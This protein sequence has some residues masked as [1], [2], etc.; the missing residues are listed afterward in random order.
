MEESKKPIHTLILDSGPILKNDPGVSSLLGQAEVLM[1]VP[2]VITEIRDIQARSRLE[3]TLLPFLTQRE[4]RPESLQVIA[5]FARKTGDYEVLSRTD[6]QVLALA[7]DVECERNEGDWR[8]RKVPGQKRVNGA[9]PMNN[10]GLSQEGEE[11]L[12]VMNEEVL[13]GQREQSLDGAENAQ[14]VSTAAGEVVD[15][16]STQPDPSPDTLTDTMETLHLSNS[17]TIEEEEVLNEPDTT[18]HPKES[19]ADSPEVEITNISPSE[20]DMEEEHPVDPAEAELSDDEKEGWI[21]PSNLRRHQKRDLDPTSS[22]KHASSTS[23]TPSQPTMQA[24]VLTSDFAIQ[25]VLLQMNLNLISSSFHQIR[26]LKTYILRC[27]ACFTKTKEMTRQFCS[28]CGKP[29]LTRVSCSTNSKG[30]FKLHLKRNM[31]WNTRGEKFSIPK[32][33]AGKA[34][35]KLNGGGG[36]KNGWGQGLILAEDQKEYQRSLVMMG[37]KNGKKMGEGLWDDDYLPGILSGDRTPRNGNGGGRV[38]VG[39]GRDVNSRR[40][41]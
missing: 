39:A 28:S 31:Q 17:Q 20:P 35:G 9:C 13:E 34:N 18:Q 24:A 1:T 2:S 21:T 4:P 26:H 14:H 30:E 32:P 37:R 22:R 11:S 15:Q 27:H 23:S 10:N 16:E 41:R 8:L 6:L 12:L 25:N 40:R 38:K 33:V 3:T 7:Y 36:G 19:P 29:T 5:E